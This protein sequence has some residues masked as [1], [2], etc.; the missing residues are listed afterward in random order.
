MVSSVYSSA[1]HNLEGTNS[2]T[3]PIVDVAQDVWRD[4]QKK[5]AVFL[6]NYRLTLWQ[7]PPRGQQRSQVSQITCYGASDIGELDLDGDGDGPFRRGSVGEGGIWDA[8]LV[9]STGQ[10]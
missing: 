9:M 7:Q 6:Q 3:M 5:H 8:M 4:R 10:V 1:A 2:R